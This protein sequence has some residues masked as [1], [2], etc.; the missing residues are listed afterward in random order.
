MWERCARDAWPP[1]GTRSWEWTSTQKRIGFLGMAFKPDTDDLR[2][3]PLVSVIE[4]L[5]GKGYAIRIYDR[6]VSTSR[7]IGANRRF[8][9]EHIPH[10]SSLLVASAEE[11]A[12]EV[13]VVVI[14]YNSPWHRLGFP[15]TGLSLV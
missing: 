5:L 15:D 8:M 3:S 9:E 14:G 2:E 13:D 4:T 11:L 1:R 12:A 10:L 6:N 7:L